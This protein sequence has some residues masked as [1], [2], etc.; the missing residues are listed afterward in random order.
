MS[1]QSRDPDRSVAALLEPG[2][3]RDGLARAEFDWRQTGDQTWTITIVPEEGTEILLE[4]GGSRLSVDGRS[5][6]SRASGRV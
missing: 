3:Q 1:P 6:T 5:E 4:N 2:R